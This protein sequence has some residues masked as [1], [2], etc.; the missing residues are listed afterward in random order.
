MAGQQ[1][2]YLCKM[3]TYLRYREIVE[4]HLKADNGEYRIQNITSQ[5]LSEYLAMKYKSGNLKTA[6]ALSAS[7]VNIIRTV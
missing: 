7:T 1:S 6:G 2:V 3:R 4:N 5:Q